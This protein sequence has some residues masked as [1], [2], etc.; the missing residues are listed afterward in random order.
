MFVTIAIPFY[1]AEKFLLD[2]IKSVF[3]QTHNKW[4]LILI[5]DGSTDKSLEIAK[6][7]N[8]PR[9]RVFSDGKNKKLAARLN[10]VVKLAKYDLIARMDADDLMSPTR[11][12]KQVSILK[13][14]PSID[15]VTTGLFSVTDDLQPIS[16]RWNKSKTIS[17]SQLLRRNIVV[18]A[19]IVA[20]KSWFERNP[21]DTNLKVAQ[22][23]N[24]WLRASYNN[25]FKL[26][27][28][29]EALYY[30]REENNTNIKKMLLA[31][32]YGRK[33]FYKYGGRDKYFLIL[34]SYIKNFIA[35][36]IV[37]LGMNRLLLKRRGKSIMDKNLLNRFYKEIQ[38][39][40]I[41]II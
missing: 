8:D 40:K 15:L 25:D 23:Y 11:I 5:D 3:V 36:S 10:E 1:N 17:H 33:M 38:L 7:I 22:D 21:Y 24:S 9:V 14:N 28:M 27:F 35:V 4:E 39:I 26:Q 19:A 13:N 30:Y 12:E 32:K 16:V 41:T 31:G 37:I 29:P 6:S 34:R 18:H 2:A 20:R